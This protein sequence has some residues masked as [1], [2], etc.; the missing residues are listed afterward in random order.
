MTYFSVVTSGCLLKAW[1]NARATWLIVVF[2]CL[3][4]FKSTIMTKVCFILFIALVFC[5][6]LSEYELILQI[7]DLICHE[8]CFD[9]ST[10]V[11]FFTFADG[12]I[13]LVVLFPSLSTMIHKVFILFLTLNSAILL[14]LRRIGLSLISGTWATYMLPWIC[15]LNFSNSMDSSFLLKACRISTN[16]GPVIWYVDPL[17]VP[18]IQGFNLSNKL[19]QI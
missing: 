16:L 8:S 5:S 14:W 9:S 13:I 10:I 1:S 15:F 18:S 19:W 11:L 7:M 12:L 4:I 6:L 3:L 17:E 2:P